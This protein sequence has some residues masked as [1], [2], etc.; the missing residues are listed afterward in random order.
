MFRLL[1]A[2][3]EYFILERLKNLLDY[4]KYDFDLCSTVNN[5]NDAYEF[6]IEQEPDLAILDIKMPYLSGLEIAEKVC[7]KKCRTKIIILTSYDYFSFAQQSIKYHVFS[8]LLKPIKKEEL[9]QV[10]IEA[11]NV[12]TKEREDT[13]HLQLYES[14]KLERLF[15]SFLTN[16][17][18]SSSDLSILI[19]H[20]VFSGNSGKWFFILLK[21]SNPDGEPNISKTVKSY[22]TKEAIIPDMYSFLCSD[23][24]VGMLLHGEDPLEYSEALKEFHSKL[25]SE[26]NV[27]IN[28]A[29]STVCSVINDL[30]ALFGH[31]AKALTYTLFCGNNTI[32]FYKDFPEFHSKRMHFNFRENLLLFLHISD[33]GKIEKLLDESFS[34]LCLET[35]SEYNLV[36]L[37]SEIYTTCNLY[38]KDINK[39]SDY[40]ISFYIHE[41]IENYNDLSEIKIWCLNYLKRL[42]ADSCSKNNNI[43][44]FTENIMSI[45]KN[46]Y[47]DP[48]LDLAYIS[49]K[50]GYSPSYVS[51][52]FK[53]YTN[54]SIVQ[55][56]TKCRME[57]AQKLLTENKLKIN[58]ICHLIGYTDSFY[59]SKR[60]KS[61]YGYSPTDYINMKKI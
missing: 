60:F 35:P 15:F 18:I 26:F 61:F 1:I 46:S 50:A 32:L 5:G 57:A 30:P 43:I 39:L 20:P 28:I 31:I 3:D 56:I 40:N 59:F 12:L 37:L 10:L 52:I 33:L 29:V 45:I 41:L 22:I 44:E 17:K 55:Y 51:S 14:E 25:I 19:N 47:T 49:G 24:I 13:L 34:Q 36:I 11:A 53:S 23:N 27:S 58:E 2:D 21:I 6:I 16:E 42:C 38:L 54:C 48:S 7:Q 8:Y 4:S 9:S